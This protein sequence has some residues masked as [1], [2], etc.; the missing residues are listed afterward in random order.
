MHLVETSLDHLPDLMSWFP[1][2][3]STSI[4]GGPKQRFP[5]TAESFREDTMLDEVPSYSLIG[6]GGE[7]L[8]FGQYYE[9]A[10][11]CHLARL[12]TAPDQRRRGLGVAL[13]RELSRL[14]CERLG[15]GVCSLFVMAD[16]APARGL[17]EKLG[18]A[19]APFPPGSPDLEGC[20]YMTALLETVL[21]GQESPSPAIG[22]LGNAT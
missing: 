4:W 19:P 18:F 17:Y 13:V 16:N 5:F 10:G 8:A 12:A 6:D 1:D 2:A 11:R 14:G 3:E 15:V 7:L 21:A 20:L 9:R 22:T